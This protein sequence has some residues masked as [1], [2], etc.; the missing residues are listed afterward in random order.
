MKL[1][2]SRYAL[3]ACAVTAAF[4]IAAA[5]PPVLAQ[6][7]LSADPADP[8]ARVPE[9][10]YRTLLPGTR[11][12][13]LRQTDVERLPWRRLFLPDGGFNDAVVGS[14]A[15]TRS[16]PMAPS[17]AAGSGEREVS[18]GSDA[19]GVVK[20]VDAKRGRVKLKHGPIQ[21]LDMPGMTM[22]F[23]VKDPKLLEN[24]KKGDEVGFTVE[25]EGSAFYVTGIQE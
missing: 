20:Y 12:E 16:D 6:A 21:K 9:T 3:R 4:S 1:W 25:M 15:T 13:Y 19:R 5:S 8:S 11:E 24:L 2:S 7:I 10:S 23:R 14:A 18:N 22:V 17:R